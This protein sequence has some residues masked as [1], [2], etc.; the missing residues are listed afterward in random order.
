LKGRCA[1]E[2]GF[3]FGI[4]HCEKKWWRGLGSGLGSHDIDQEVSGVV[5]V[6][7]AEGLLIGF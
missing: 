7:E 5:G 3:A 6:G 2:D 4:G 1:L